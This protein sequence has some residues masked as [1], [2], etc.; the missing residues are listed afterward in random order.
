VPI[1]YGLPSPEMM[2]EAERGE[3]RLG[4]CFITGDDPEWP[5]LEAGANPEWGCI[6]CPWPIPD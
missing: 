2:E 6:D 3:A 5:S 1:V 4:G